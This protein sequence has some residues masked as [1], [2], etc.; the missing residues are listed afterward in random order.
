M[1]IDRCNSIFELFTAFNF[2]YAV[3]SHP[4]D[5]QSSFSNKISHVTFVDII[6][7]Y[8]IKPF[9]ELADLLKPIEKRLS[10]VQESLSTQREYYKDESAKK[11][12]D[13]LLFQAND[14]DR[15][16]KVWK[17]R[18]DAKEN[19]AKGRINVRFPHA[20]FILAL[21][22]ISVLVLA[23]SQSQ[24]KHLTL[25]LLDIALCIEV[26]WFF[27]LPEFKFN[28]ISYRALLY[29]YL[30]LLLFITVVHFGTKFYIQ[31]NLCDLYHYLV[32]LLDR[33]E[34][35]RPFFVLINLTIPS[36]HFLFYYSS[37][38]NKISRLKKETIQRLI[39]FNDDLDLIEEGQS[40]LGNYSF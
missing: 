28:K 35:V 32:M 20:S 21:F 25:L 33:N 4:D 15:R 23:T 29:T 34:E 16:V 11:A 38:L 40:E 24:H 13:E 14:V 2:T 18:I 5:D 1:D 37:F 17:S 22:C 27:M 3:L 26:I 31:R 10:K 12:C 39:V 7:S 6:D 36:W 8:L 9:N 19:L 30:S